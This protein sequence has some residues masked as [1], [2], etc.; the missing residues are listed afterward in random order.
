MRDIEPDRPAAHED[1]EDPERHGDHRVQADHEDLVERAAEAEDQEPEEEPD[2]EMAPRRFDS[3]RRRSA[4]GGM[5]TGIAL[6][7]QEVFYPTKNEPVI[8]AE[9][10]GEPPDADD[11]LRVIL[12]PDDPTKSIVLLPKADPPPSDG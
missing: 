5:A 8:S 3:W 9:A 4:V 6:G 1:H 10:P 11:R 2:E 7:L 12:D